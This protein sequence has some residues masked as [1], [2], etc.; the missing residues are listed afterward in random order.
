MALKKL[1]G[2]KSVRTT[3]IYLSVSQKLLREAMKKH[4]LN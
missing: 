2:H 1:A 4:P 3:Q